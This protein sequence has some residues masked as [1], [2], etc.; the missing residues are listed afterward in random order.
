M[1]HDCSIRHTGVAVLAAGLLMAPAAS[2]ADAF[3]IASG[4]T[5]TLQQSLNAGEAGSIREGGTLDTGSDPAVLMPGDASSLH[6]AGVIRTLGAVAAGI[7]ASGDAVSISNTGLIETSGFAASG[8]SS[9]G[10]GAILAN[11]GLIT[12]SGVG[13]S[14]IESMGDDAG[15][16]NSGRLTTSGFAGTGITSFGSSAGI[17]NHGSITASGIEGIGISSGGAAASIFNQGSIVASGPF[18]RGILLFS[19]DDETI[20]SNAGLI[21]ATGQES[22]AIFGDAGDTTLN[23]LPSSR[24]LGRIDL[25]SGDD[26]VN[27]MGASP[28]SATLAFTNTE[29]I[30]LR[31]APGLVVGSTVTLVDPTGP[32]IQ[33]MLINSIVTTIHS[34]LRQHRDRSAQPVQVATRQ[35]APGIY[36][37]QQATRAWAEVFGTRQRRGGDGMISSFEHDFYGLM[38]GLEKG[39]G[40]KRLGFFGGA[41]RSNADSSGRSYASESDVLFVGGY[42]RWQA[43]GLDLEAS[44]IAGRAD[45]DSERLVIDNLNGM[46][47]AQADYDSYFLSPSLT[48]AASHALNERMTL[49][50]SASVAYSLAWQE[51]Y[52]ESGTTQSNLH[53]E[54]RTLRV[55]DVRAQLAA[56]YRLGRQCEL[57]ARAALISRNGDDGRLHASLAG[58]N[59]RFSAEGDD[60][61]VGGL[62]GMALRMPLSAGLGLIAEAE[63]TRA[64]SDERAWQA[65]A[66]LY[67]EF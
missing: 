21:A 47:R 59:F 32:G 42:S 24:I 39:F 67:Y 57:E 66:A 50:P 44:L 16:A 58:A 25:G 7:S 27:I 8:M 6:N 29:Q 20:V 49:R 15:I 26:T 48:L 53:I 14:A 36:P 18:G 60:H 1:P 2:W 12:T 63:F 31:G 4:E 38:G 33:G 22:Y 28:Y 3:T 46:E 9:S 19:A 37:E 62:L 56:I 51:S 41:V 45:H 23:L 43:G 40:Q 52:R 55:L 34:T 17:V 54:D 13:A 30:N 35:L 10:T 65:N 5:V 61:V 11:R 64:E